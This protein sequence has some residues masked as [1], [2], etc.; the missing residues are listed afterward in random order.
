[1]LPLLHL[2]YGF[3]LALVQ[4]KVFFKF[5]FSINFEFFMGLRMSNV[6]AFICVTNKQS[7]LQN[8]W[9]FR[10]RLVTPAQ[11]LNFAT[12]T[13]EN[14]VLGAAPSYQVGME[15]KLTSQCALRVSVRQQEALLEKTEQ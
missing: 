5:R 14:Q 2:N 7:K 11:T 1:M 3:F 9:V 10:S 6:Q 12:E 4:G 15:R 13:Q 8:V